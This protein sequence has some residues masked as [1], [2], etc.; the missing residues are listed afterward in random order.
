M[1]RL[2]IAQVATSDKS[3]YLL[4]LDQIKALQEMGY[5]V[6]AVCAPGQWVER[7]RQQGVPVDTIGMVRELSPIHDLKSLIALY[8]YFRKR[9]FDV[10][11]THTPKAGLLGPLAAKL[12]CVP[13][14][15]HTIHGLLFHDGMPMWKRMIFY[16]PEKL[17]A[18]FSDFLLSQSQ[19]DIAVAIRTKLCSP[20]KIKYLGNGIDVTRFSPGKEYLDRSLILRELGL[21]EEDFVIGSVGR[22]VYEKGFSELFIAAEELTQKYPH[23]KFVIVGSHEEDQRDSVDSQ[24]IEL[25]KQR[26]AILF[27]DWQEDMF[28][29]YSIMDMFVLPSHREGIPR[30]CME[31]A[32][33]MR[34]IIT[35]NIRGCRE[36]VRDGETGFLVPL[37][38]AK[39]LA[40][41]MEQLIHDKQR[42]IEMGEMGR[43]H[44]VENFNINLVIERLGNIYLMIE[45]IVTQRN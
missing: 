7:I 5:E 13:V 32:A 6:T 30:A 28:K 36:V 37:K 19:E 11:H 9:K 31:A 27:L 12:S 34:P 42:R 21:K 16:L 3:I 23:V 33:M 17:T 43:R 41:A 8:G 4:L 25:L 45:P 2:K 29:W 20:K 44:I 18:T 10:V 22:L 38:N 26:G 35:T 14:V 15:I 40:N 24:W 1:A 39:A